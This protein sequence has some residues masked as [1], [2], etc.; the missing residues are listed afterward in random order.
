MRRGDGARGRAVVV[1]RAEGMSRRSRGG[2]VPRFTQTRA[3]GELP[4]GG[5]GG[6]RCGA[7]SETR[8]RT[9]ARTR[10]RPRRPRRSRTALRTIRESS[11]LRLSAPR[12]PPSFENG[13]RARAP[14]TGDGDDKPRE[15]EAVVRGSIECGG[16][17]TLE[18]SSG[19]G[20][21][22]EQ[23]AHRQRVPFERPLPDAQD[24]G[25]KELSQPLFAPLFQRGV[26]F[27]TGSRG[28]DSIGGTH[29]LTDE[30]TESLELIG[31]AFLFPPASRTS[32][33]TTSPFRPGG[34]NR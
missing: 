29:D 23:C 10:A 27:Q 6:A 2:A 22:A 15:E 11:C 5:R 31:S 14:R 9:R 17:S 30:L 16:A 21:R 34:E 13:N 26:R 8:G 32:A 28:F 20:E 1:D 18:T 12:E 4:T 33:A 25:E 3:R 7:A 24:V 19:S